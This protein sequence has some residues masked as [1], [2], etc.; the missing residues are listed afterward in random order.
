MKALSIKQPWAWLI[1]NGH[2]DIEN[3]TWKTNFRGQFLIH[4]SKKI[5]TRDLDWGIMLKLL[6]EKIGKGA[7]EYL[8][9]NKKLFTVDFNVG[10]IIGVAEIVDCTA[11]S[12][13]N[14]FEG[15]IGFVIRNARPLPFFPCK[16]RLGFFEVEYQFEI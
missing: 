15:P 3:R 6:N 11:W 12:S 4:A 1:A 10:G 14:W 7:T 5:D 2:K 13:S 8:R 9:V 16:G